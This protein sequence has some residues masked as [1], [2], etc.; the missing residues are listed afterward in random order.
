MVAELTLIVGGLSFFMAVFVKGFLQYLYAKPK[1]LV[2][3]AFAN[4]GMPSL[5]SAFMSG[6]VFSIY[7]SEGFSSVFVLGLA[8]MFV[9]F[10]DAVRVRQNLGL[11]GLALNKALSK[12]HIQGVKVVLGHTGFQVFI[13]FLIGFLCS[14]IFF[15]FV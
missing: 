1:N 13:G 5:H 3:S 7:F 2:R 12:L 9:T 4:G 8:I 10:S 14:L 11:Q 15:N 6:I